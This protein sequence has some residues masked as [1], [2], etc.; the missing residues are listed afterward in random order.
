MPLTEVELEQ[1]LF[2]KVEGEDSKRGIPEALFI[3][4]V[5]ELCAGRE[6]SVVVAKLQDLH[7]K[8]Q[9][10][11]SSLSA[12]RA[13]LKT[14]LPDISCALE[15]VNHLVE[16]KE[17]AAEGETADYTY[18]LAENIWSKASAP[19]VSTV[20]LWLG[21]N[22]MLEYTLEEAVELLKTNET[23]AKT[24]LKGLEEDMAFL[25]DQI[26]TTE[27]NIARSHN[28]GVKLRQLAKDGKEGE[29]PSEGAAAS[30]ASQASSKAGSGGAYTWKQEKE[31]V[32]V[33]V[34]MP[35]DA[36][37]SDVKVT[38]LADSLKVEHLGKVLLQGDLAGKCS[39]NGST[40]TMTG[41]RVEI[42]LEKADQTAWPALFD[43]SS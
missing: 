42:T 8:Y 1:R 31:E 15:T 21:A 35:K 20:C 16:R 6:T 3:E 32:E 26:T 5:E 19:P 2:R 18:Q 22:C 40:W 30:S 39:P 38:I 14:K 29:K 28:Y 36:Q 13:S 41:S 11:Q 24:S 17:K 34:R 37:K 12:Q 7:S 43:S 27:V 33:S 9:Y 23:N 25:R 10:M 4:N